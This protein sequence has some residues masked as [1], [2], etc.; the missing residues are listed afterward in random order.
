MFTARLQLSMRPLA[1]QATS[2]D[3]SLRRLSSG[4]RVNQASDDAAG[5]SIAAKLRSQVL[6]FNQ[7]S[8]P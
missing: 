6:G 5:L 7:A 3:R 1:L 2:L 8:R 4:L